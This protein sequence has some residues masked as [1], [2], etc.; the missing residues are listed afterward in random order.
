MSSGWAKSKSFDGLLTRSQDTVPPTSDFRSVVSGNTPSVRD[1]DP[2]TLPLHAV[3]GSSEEKLTRRRHQEGNL[4]KLRHGWACRFY[5]DYY[6]N[7]ERLRRRI[8]QFL[9]DFKKLP[10]KRSAQNAMDERLAGVNNFTVRPRTTATFAEFAKLWLEKCRTRKRKPIKPST[11]LNWE[12]ILDNHVLPVLGSTPLSSVE[13]PAVKILVEGLVRKGLSPQTIKNI[14]QVVK[15]TKASAKDENSGQ[16]L[17]PTKWDHELIDLPEVDKK[18]QHKPSFTIAEVTKIVQAARGRLQMVCILFAATGM[19]A[20]E[21]LGLETKH[22]DGAALTVSQAVWSSKVQE[23]KT[24]NARRIVDLHPDVAALLKTFIGNR[25]AGF[26]FKAGSGR[27]LAQSNL[28]R[29]EFHPLLES[30]EIEPCGFHAF[31][32]FRNTFL[33]QRHCPDGVLKFWMGHAD[34]DLSDTYD[35]SRD[36]VVFRR[37]V[38]NSMGT[39]FEVP[40]ALSPRPKQPVQ[41]IT[42]PGVIGR[43]AEAVTVQYV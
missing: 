17:Y 37:D 22:F 28:L 13:N 27:P 41:N 9:G 40:K 29:R 12:S 18:K 19:R 32:R 4:I 36:D 5:E 26:I 31:R 3:T 39:G 15:L 1:K 24:P 30:L 10:T 38:A 35:R 14:V 7:G 23:P 33:R 20:G 25:T 34:E 43:Q 16:Q 6:H 11:L 2:S 21:L 42:K 8:R